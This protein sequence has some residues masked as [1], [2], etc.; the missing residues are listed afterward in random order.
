MQIQE[1]KCEI[2]FRELTIWQEAWRWLVTGLE[3]W[4][5]M[6]DDEKALR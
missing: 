5:Q 4:V 2:D 3:G 6:R 1:I